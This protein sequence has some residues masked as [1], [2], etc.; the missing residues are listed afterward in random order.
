MASVPPTPATPAFQ[1][2]ADQASPHLPIVGAASSTALAFTSFSFPGA[3]AIAKHIRAERGHM[4]QC[5]P[6][7][8]GCAEGG[9]RPGVV[10]RG[11]DA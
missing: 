9:G 11:A 1:A 4:A 3:E 6:S 7:I 10:A 2:V 8:P 5:R